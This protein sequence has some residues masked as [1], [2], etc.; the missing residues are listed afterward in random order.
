MSDVQLYNRI[1]SFP[2]DLKKQVVDFVEFLE[3]KSHD[4][5]EKK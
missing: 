2:E 4:K 3:A 5:V 1:T